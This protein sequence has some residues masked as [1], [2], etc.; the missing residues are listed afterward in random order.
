MTQFFGVI[1][2][3]LFVQV[4]GIASEQQEEP[5][6]AD[7]QDQKATTEST[8]NNFFDNLT[9]FLPKFPAAS[10]SEKDA[11]AA[12]STTL[13]TCPCDIVAKVQGGGLYAG[14]DKK[15]RWNLSFIQGTGLV[16]VLYAD[17]DLRILE[18]PTQNDGGWE[19]AGLIVVQVRR[20]LLSSSSA[21]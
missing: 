15:K 5:E 3:G 18:S 20:D 21:D 6:T 17:P 4:E 19:D 14:S 1:S 13:R 8:G 12:S 9:D 10:K 7:D 11:T 2:T 16:R